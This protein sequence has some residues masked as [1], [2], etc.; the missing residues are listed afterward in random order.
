MQFQ[1]P[2]LPHPL[3]KVQET[4]NP[5]LEQ[6]FFFVST[7]VSTIPVNTKEY[8]L[9]TTS[10]LPPSTN[11]KVIKLHL[12]SICHY[13][14][15]ALTIQGHLHILLQKHIIFFL[16]AH[17]RTKENLSILDVTQENLEVIPPPHCLDKH[18]K[19][20]EEIFIKIRKTVGR[21]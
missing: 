16:T 15:H 19:L 7:L 8:L 5:S 9:I 6:L 4:Y 17:G 10:L 3:E 2:R 14:F 11:Y 1:Q 13:K 18:Q 20:K 21:K 12:K